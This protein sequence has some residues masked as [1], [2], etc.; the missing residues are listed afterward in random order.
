MYEDRGLH[1]LSA[2]SLETQR[3]G[4][5]V[6]PALFDT[7][8]AVRSIPGSHQNQAAACWK[9]EVT[10]IVRGSGGC[11]VVPC[12]P[13]E[14]REVCE[15]CVFVQSNSKDQLFWI[16]DLADTGSPKNNAVR[17]DAKTEYSN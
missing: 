4:A 16:V 7:P 5:K 11:R 17:E 13:C 8:H 9:K 10:D 14:V 15:V 6:E 2:L 12:E 1:L 3:R